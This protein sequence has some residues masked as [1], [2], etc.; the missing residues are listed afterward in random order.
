[1]KNIFAK[2]GII[3]IS[4]MTIGLPIFFGLT[5]T[6][7]RVWN[8]WFHQVQVADDQTN[9]Q[10]R[11]NVEDTCR[12]M[13]AS[14]T[15]DKLIYEQYKNSEDSLE[16]QMANNAKT[17]ANQTART[18]NNYIIKNRYVWRDNVPSDIYMTLA[19]IE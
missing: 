17:R 13:I 8:N 14:Y 15:N 10:T 5:P 4:L 3:F 6:G 18:Y 9:Y 2:I 16:K 7:K 19:Y 11:K 1:M 12:A